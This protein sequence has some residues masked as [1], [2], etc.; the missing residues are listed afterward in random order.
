MNFVGGFIV[1]YGEF[2]IDF[3]LIVVGVFLVEVLVFKKVFGGVFVNVVVCVSWFG[4]N[5][6]F[7]GKVGDDEFGYMFVDVLMFNKVDVEGLWFDFNVC[8]VFVFVIFR[9]D[10]E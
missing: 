1:V 9:S 2:L 3:V 6:V 5:V 7:I 4:G 10:G 8:M